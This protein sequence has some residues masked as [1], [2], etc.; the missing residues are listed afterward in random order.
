[1]GQE[2]VTVKGKKICVEKGRLLFL[3][4]EIANITKIEGL[5]NLTSLEHLDFEFQ[6]ID[7]LKGLEHLTSLQRIDLAGNPIR[8]D[9]KHFISIGL[10]DAQEM[11]KYCQEKVKKSK[12][13][14]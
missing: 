2:F 14:G 1:M 6:Q 13:G 3:E 10:K 9:E 11:V 4:T 12:E 7:E 5:E 8:D